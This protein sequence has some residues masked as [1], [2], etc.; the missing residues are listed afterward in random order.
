MAAYIQGLYT[1]KISSRTHWNFHEK[2]N[3]SN[4]NEIC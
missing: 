2:E 1:D 3:R 4:E